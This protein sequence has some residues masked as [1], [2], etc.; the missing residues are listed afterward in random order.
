M[1]VRWLMYFINR[2]EDTYILVRLSLLYIPPVLEV[3]V[4][5]G[6]R[7]WHC[8]RVVG[9]LYWS[10]VWSVVTITR[11][12]WLTDCRCPTSLSASVQL[13]RRAGPASTTCP[14]GLVVLQVPTRTPP[15]PPPLLTLPG[16]SYWLLLI[17]TLDT[18]GHSRTL[19]L[20]RSDPRDK[21]G[22]RLTHTHSSY[23]H[24][25]ILL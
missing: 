5:S 7:L 24:P 8:E 6:V 9:S 12:A 25:R 15:P 2:S 22:M 18:G 20:T 17:I 13:S 1:S 11:E 19:Y 16:G 4:D 10:A 23:N 21:P 14:A 3:V